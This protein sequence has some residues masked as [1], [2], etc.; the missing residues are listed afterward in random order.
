MLC[1]TLFQCLMGVVQHLQLLF[2]S[3][4]SV[5]MHPKCKTIWAWVCKAVS[6]SVDDGTE[7]ATPFTLFVVVLLFFSWNF[8]SG[9]VCT[10]VLRK[11]LIAIWPEERHENHRKISIAIAHRDMWKKKERMKEM[12]SR[13]NDKMHA[14][15]RENWRAIIQV[16]EPENRDRK[17]RWT[18]FSRKT[19]SLYL[20]HRT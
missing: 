14:E 7:P 19:I 2:R 18:N 9:A 11:T 17:K 3:H 1:M 5:R 8:S 13:N 20:T 16:S 6:Q 15:M 10:V 4:S 12:T